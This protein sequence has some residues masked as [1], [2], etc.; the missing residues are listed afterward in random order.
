M[1]IVKELSRAIKSVPHTFPPMGE[2][3]TESLDGTE[4]QNR[5]NSKK[6]DCREFDVLYL[7]CQT[8]EESMGRCVLFNLCFSCFLFCPSAAPFEISGYS[9]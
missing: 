6:S 8:V 7:G 3:T 5:T 4:L 1:E 2:S 9:E